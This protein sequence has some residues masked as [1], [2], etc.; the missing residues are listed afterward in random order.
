[1]LE[2]YLP[3]NIGTRHFNSLQLLDNTYTEKYSGSVYGNEKE[4][5]CFLPE[6]FIYKVSLLLKNWGH[7]H[8]INIKKLKR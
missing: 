1:M 3:L 5:I 6:N 4:C 7:F 2:H 8:E